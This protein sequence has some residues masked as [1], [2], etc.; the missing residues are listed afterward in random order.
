MTAKVVAVANQK[1]GV[2]KT[3]STLN[4]AHALHER[5]LRVLAID[6]D[7]QSSLSIVCGVDDLRLR[8]LE[9]AGR[10]L[11]H[12]LVKTVPLVEL[13]IKGDLDV[14]PAS[15][16]LANAEQE[17]NSPFG[18]AT[19]LREKIAPLR[20]LYDIILIDCP[21][22]L[23]LLTVNA[24]TAADYVL[25]P[26]KTDFLSIM[27]VPLLLETIENVRN[28][29]NSRLTLIGI[30]PTM[31][32]TTANHDAALLSELREL[33]EQQHIT[34]FDPVSRATAFD[35]AN[36]SGKSALEMYP[37]TRGVDQY[38]VVADKIISYAA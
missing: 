2:G 29:A 3:T 13:I 10:T 19:I 9:Q 4:I 5:G 27:G 32:L 11:Y 12:G 28:R 21:P 35:K 25:I 36:A 16:R 37:T 26:V 18:A 8:D 30:L 22:T 23:S 20:A 31:F 7:P 1:G 34:V 6:C 17:L 15:I 14:I 38:R 33:A 24:L